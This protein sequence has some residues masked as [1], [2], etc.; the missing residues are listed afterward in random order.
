MSKRAKTRLDLEGLL[1]SLS[2]NMFPDRFGSVP[3]TLD[4]RAAD[5]DTPLHTVIRQNNLYG[6]K[7]LI[8]AGADLD[9]IGNQGETPLHAAVFER[10]EALMELLLAAGA[11][12]SIVC[13]RGLTPSELAAEADPALLKIFKTTQK[14]R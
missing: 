6:T 7:L 11:D 3:V 14:S 2:E 8:E 12:A 5:G 13:G 1:A 9:A 10:N 4:T